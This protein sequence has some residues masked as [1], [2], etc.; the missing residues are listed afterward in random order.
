MAKNRK[1]QA[2]SIRFGPALVASFALLVIAGASVGYVWQ[3]GQIIQLGKQY[4][5][6]ENRLAQLRDDN[7][8]MTRMLA[9]MKSPLR[10]DQRVQELKLGL[11]PAQP[12]QV[13]R[14]PEPPGRNDKDVPRQFAARPNQETTQ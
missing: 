13:Y 2:A 8:R 14:L 7:E 12:S 10:L 1:N 4:H 9:D 6:A 3:K 5:A 11:V